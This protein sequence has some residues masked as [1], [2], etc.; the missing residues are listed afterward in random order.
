MESVSLMGL[1]S[2][3]EKNGKD[4]ALTEGARFYQG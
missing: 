2:E 1:C 3:E 4:L